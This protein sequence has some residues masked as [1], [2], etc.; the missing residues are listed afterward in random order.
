MPGLVG[1]LL[2]RMTLLQAAWYSRC[3]KQMLRGLLS[4]SCHFG[5]CKTAVLHSGPDKV[6]HTGHSHITPLANCGDTILWL[7]RLWAV[8]QVE[9]SKALQQ[10]EKEGVTHLELDLRGNLGGL[11]SQGVE[12]ARLFLDSASH[13]PTS[14]KSHSLR[15]PLFHTT[16]R[17]C[18]TR[19]CVQNTL[20]CIVV[21]ILHD[22]GNTTFT[23]AVFP[24]APAGACQCGWG[25][26]VAL[27]LQFT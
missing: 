22:L 23:I 18:K 15:R 24:W 1:P 3:C 7:M 13:V 12:T 26:G 20:Q 8:G 27:P 14:Q 19:K 6:S 5:C 2:L 11:V 9:V 21:T 10:C 17:L 4:S 25:M 16:K